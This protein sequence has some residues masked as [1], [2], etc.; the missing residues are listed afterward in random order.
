M[1]KKLFA[2][3]DPGKSGAIVI[4]S[5]EGD[6]EFKSVVPV[7]GKEYDKQ[8]VKDILLEWDSGDNCIVHAMIEN[9]HAIQGNVGGT[10]NFNFGKGAML[11]EMA[12]V[13]LEIPHTLISP[14]LWQKE[15]WSGGYN[16]I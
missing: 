9:V 10:S 3:M 6:I 14:A 16:T 12:V 11:W 5:E 13:C 4:L 15:A 2:G 8:A 1:T 7:I